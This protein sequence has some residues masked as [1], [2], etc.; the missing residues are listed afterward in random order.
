MMRRAL[1]YAVLTAGALVTTFPFIWMVSTA[2]KS[3]AEAL[4]AGLDIF[5]ERL[6][7]SNFVVMF[8]EAPEFGT[9]FY[10]SLFLFKVSGTS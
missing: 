7:W 8:R 5:P 10:N 4:T 3:E 9:Y 6:M 2:L 1:I